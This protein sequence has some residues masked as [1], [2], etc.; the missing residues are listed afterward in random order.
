M[1][2]S[3][4]GRIRFD[5][6]FIAVDV[7]RDDFGSPSIIARF[8]ARQLH[9]FT[10]EASDPTLF[11][12]LDLCVAYYALDRFVKRPMNGFGRTFVLRYPVRSPELWRRN[13]PLVRQ[14]LLA[15]TDDDVEVVPVPWRD[16]GDHHDRMQSLSLTEPVEAVGLLSDGLDSLCGLDAALQESRRMAWVSVISGHRRKRI[17]AMMELGSESEIA[18]I[19]HYMIRLRLKRGNKAKEKTQRSRTVLAVAMGMTLA[20]ALGSDTVECYENGFGLLNLPVPDL[21]YGGMSSQVL[22]PGHLPL[23]DQI[24]RAFFGRT[25][26]VRY[27]NRFRTKGEML[28]SLSPA[29]LALVRETFSCDA[30]YRQAKRRVFHC[31]TCGSC[32]I[33]Q[34]SIAS[35][36]IESFDAH[37][38]YVSRKGDA[39]EYAALLRYHAGLLDAALRSEDPWLALNRLQSSIAIVPHSDDLRVA[40]RASQDIQH[41]REFLQL[42]TLELLR[43]HVAELNTWRPLDHAA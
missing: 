18:A 32:R 23:W 39:L 37:Y 15:L 7:D 14:W 10:T 29:A 13:V 19:D 6:H 24:S 21:Q 31:G 17:S 35:A 33:R 5:G 34:L 8:D 41:H 38:A 20:H 3:V 2:P 26:E 43:R 30:G 25:I 16:A 4:A 40:A 11:E 36:R 9:P 1:N 27:P 12:L 22:Q 28:K 42:Q